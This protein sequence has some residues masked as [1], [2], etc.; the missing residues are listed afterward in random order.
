MTFKICYILQK[1]TRA[2]Y[3][4]FAL[5]VCFRLSLLSIPLIWKE[6]CSTCI[7]YRKYAIDK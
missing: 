5:I 3:G 2:K 1:S 6:D 4:P 7:D